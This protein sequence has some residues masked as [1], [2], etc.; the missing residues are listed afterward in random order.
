MPFRLRRFH[1]V[2]VGGIQHILY[3]YSIPLGW[4][5]YHHMGDSSDELAVLNDGAA[6]HECGQVGT[7]V[8][9]K[10]FKSQKRK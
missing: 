3:K 1:H 10:K 9:N 2:N 4:L 8:F 7:T 5:G 6:A